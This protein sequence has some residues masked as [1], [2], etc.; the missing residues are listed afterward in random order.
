MRIKIDKKYTVKELPTYAIDI[1]MAG[2]IEQA[3][4]LIAE[5]CFEVG[6][7]VHIHPQTFIYTGG[8]E[9]GFKVGIVNYPRF[10][11]PEGK[12]WDA[13]YQLAD[14]LIK[15]IFQHSAMIVS[16]NRTVWFSRRDNKTEV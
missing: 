16:P 12:I 14:R 10:P 15:G 1:H 6:F 8:S 9:E 13:A 11:C 5:F 4:R 3:K 7:C 2:D